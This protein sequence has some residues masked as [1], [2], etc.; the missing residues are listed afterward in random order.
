MTNLVHRLDKLIDQ[1]AHRTGRSGKRIVSKGNLFASSVG[2]STTEEPV[3]S[4][5]VQPRLGLD[6]KF[7][8]ARKRK[9]F[10]LRRDQAAHSQGKHDAEP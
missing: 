9:N 4:F 8:K 3:C 1:N 5:I 7:S 10:V 6:S 2:I